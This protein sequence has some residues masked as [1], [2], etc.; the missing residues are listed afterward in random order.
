[1][2]Y[3]MARE[4]SANLVKNIC[5]RNRCGGVFLKTNLISGGCTGQTRGGGL[6]KLNKKQIALRTFWITPNT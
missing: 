3:V 2:K 4:R 6:T 1:M 5:M